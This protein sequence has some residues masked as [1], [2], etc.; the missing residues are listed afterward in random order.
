MFG[1]RKLTLGLC[2]LTRGENLCAHVLFTTL[3]MALLF[4]RTTASHSH[5]RGT[6]GVNFDRDI[7]AILSDKGFACH[8]ADRNKRKANF[9]LDVKEDVLA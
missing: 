3:G 2:C 9:R 4:M 6:S 7:C 5:G 1:I 8:G